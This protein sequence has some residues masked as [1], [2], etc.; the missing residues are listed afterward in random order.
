MRINRAVFWVP[1]L[2][3]LAA[4]TVAFLVW[5][6]DAVPPEEGPLS[7]AACQTIDGIFRPTGV[8]GKEQLLRHL[9]ESSDRLA[10]QTGGQ[11]REASQTHASYARLLYAE[12]R[13]QGPAVT[14]QAHAEGLGAYNTIRTNGW[15][16]C[17]LQYLQPAARN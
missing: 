11:L 8:A 12:T 9:A 15:K 17:A 16:R 7:T 3:I 4:I 2:S 1:A 14:G 6:P 13:G 10:V 5:Q